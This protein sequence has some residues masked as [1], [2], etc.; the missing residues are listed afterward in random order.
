MEDHCLPL[1]FP[2]ST[3]HRPPAEAAFLPTTQAGAGCVGRGHPAAPGGPPASSRG[4]Q[5]FT[6][7]SSPKGTAAK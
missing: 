3:T 5:L 7:E 2:R 4:L 1:L 6:L